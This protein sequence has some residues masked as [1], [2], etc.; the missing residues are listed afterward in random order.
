[1]AIYSIDLAK[2]T[3]TSTNG[4]CFKFTETKPDVYKAV[5]TNPKDIPPDD[6][7]DQILSRM[8]KEAEIQYRMEMDRKE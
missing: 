2:Q 3:A 7:V 1:M 6:L 8:V 5:C 4:V